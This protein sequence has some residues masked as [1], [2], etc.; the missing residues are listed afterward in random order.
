MTN[1]DLIIGAG[2]HAKVIA[3]ILLSRGRTV[4]G[5]LDDNPELLNK[6]ILG[7]PILGHSDDWQRLEPDGLIIGIGNNAIRKRIAQKL[8]VDARPPW[9]TAIH[10][11]TVVAASVQIGPGSVL[12][13][14]VIINADTDIG[15]HAIVNTGATIDHDC[16]VGDYAH[17]APGV[18][19]AGGVY[20]GEST[21]V[22]IG[23]VIIPQITIST[24]CTIGAGACVTK[25]ITEPGV[26]AVGVPARVLDR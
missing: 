3:D 12:M 17:I 2:G 1:G 25:S 15:A 26:T 8:S 18:H 14:G 20:I 24:N 5:F 10:A 4:V 23:A 22:G 21:F 7:L 13:P 16:V 11:E 6:R 9:I 19:M